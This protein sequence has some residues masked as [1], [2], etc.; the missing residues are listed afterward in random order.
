MEAGGVAVGE[1]VRVSKEGNGESSVCFEVDPCALAYD[2]QLHSFLPTLPT[3]RSIPST[4]I[5]GAT[6]VGGNRK[7]Q[8]QSSL[9]GFRV[10]L[11]LVPSLARRYA[12][13][14]SS[15]YASLPDIDTAPDIYETPDEDS[16]PLSQPSHDANRDSDTD[17]DDARFPNPSN[18]GKTDNATNATENINK[19]NLDTVQARRRFE[20]AAT[21][22]NQG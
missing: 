18:R 14:M 8:T 21:A 2:R 13:R 11:K 1:L 12:G 6:Q 15:K 16:L 17:S 22:R 4:P 3:P 7:T 9:L 5:H 19:A 20:E 10:G